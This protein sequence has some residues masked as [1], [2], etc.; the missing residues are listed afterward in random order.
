MATVDDILRLGEMIQRGQQDMA[1]YIVEGLRQNQ[2]QPQSWTGSGHDTGVEGDIEDED[3]GGFQG[4]A[5]ERESKAQ[6][7]LENHLSVSLFPFILSVPVYS[8]VVQAKIRAHM[9][10]LIKDRTVTQD[11]L[12]NF[13]PAYG[14]CC[15]VE[16]FRL[17][18]AGTPY[19]RWNKSAARVFVESFLRKHTEYPS[20]NKAVVDMVKFETRSTIAAMIRRYY[21]TGSDGSIDPATRKYISRQER[22]NKVCFQRPDLVMAVAYSFSGSS[23]AVAT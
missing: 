18:V 16:D 4:T 11:D 15:G 23:A 21:M 9:K 22:K 17:H 20:D 2:P 7:P 1:R 12:E 10:H 13:N 6:T 5:G 8:L 19:D 14:P 3:E